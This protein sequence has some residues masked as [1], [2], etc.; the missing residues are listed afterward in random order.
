M[1]FEK[2]KWTALTTDEQDVALRF[3]PPTF[4]QTMANNFRNCVVDVKAAKEAS[5]FDLGKI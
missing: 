1:E 3:V 2:K 5:E 4:D